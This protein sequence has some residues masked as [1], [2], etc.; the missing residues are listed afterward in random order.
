MVF[1]KSDLRLDT[2]HAAAL[3]SCDKDAV[4]WPIVIAN[5]F[6]I[7]GG[8]HNMAFMQHRCNCKSKPGHTSMSD[9]VHKASLELQTAFRAIETQ[10]ITRPNGIKYNGWQKPLDDDSDD[11]SRYRPRGRGKG[12][13]RGA[14]RKGGA[15]RGVKRKVDDLNE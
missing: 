13:G 3:L 11:Q 9:T 10:V 2:A 1:A 7:T 4:C 15:G 8:A 12:R 6:D 14:G 5:P